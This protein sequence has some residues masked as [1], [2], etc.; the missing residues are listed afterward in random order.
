MKKREHI[1]F[2][3]S[4]YFKKLEMKSVIYLKSVSR[5]DN[6]ILP[7]ELKLVR[8][9][10][11]DNKWYRLH[12]PKD[13]GWSEGICRLTQDPNDEHT[14]NG[15]AHTT[16][17]TLMVSLQ[18]LPLLKFCLLKAFA[19]YQPKELRLMTVA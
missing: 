13:N 1:D 18:V 5:V 9:S 4:T 16:E 11:S 15:I 7:Q 8:G 2:Q 17:R 6:Y 14:Y 3:K 19:F 12:M 10:K